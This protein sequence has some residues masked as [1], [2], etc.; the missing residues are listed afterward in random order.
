MLEQRIKLAKI[1][2]FQRNFYKISKVNLFKINLQIPYWIKEIT[3]KNINKIKNKT[4]VNKIHLKIKK[5]FNK[6][7]SKLKVYIWIICRSDTNL[8]N[9]I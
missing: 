6:N 4:K 9:L 5:K 8:I 3:T 7:L 1:K 2:Y